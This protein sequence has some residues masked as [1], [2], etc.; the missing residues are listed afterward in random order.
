MA[1]STGQNSIDCLNGSDRPML[2]VDNHLIPF[3]GADKCNYN[4]IISGKPKSGTYQFR[5]DC[6]IFLGSTTSVTVMSVGHFLDHILIFFI[7][8]S[9]K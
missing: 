8:G 6:E 2:T 7:M 9:R 3:T 5:F 4:F 1:V